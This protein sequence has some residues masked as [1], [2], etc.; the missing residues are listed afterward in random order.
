[1]AATSFTSPSG[2]QRMVRAL[3]RLGAPAEA[4]RF[5]AEHVEAD[6]VHEQIVRTDVVGDLVAREPD[7]EDDVVF[8]MRAFEFVE[9]RL[10]D[11]MVA[12]WTAGQTS[13]RRP[14]ED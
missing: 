7:L 5:Y 4:I 10:A 3:E 1:M 2:S 14:L 9:D 8:G 13:L 11:H 12:S 6:A